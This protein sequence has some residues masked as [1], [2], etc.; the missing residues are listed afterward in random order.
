MCRRNR[1]IGSGGSTAGGNACSFVEVVDIAEQIAPHHAFKRFRTMPYPRLP[2]VLAD[3]TG[4]MERTRFA[5]AD[6]ELVLRVE[7]PVDSNLTVRLGNN[8]GG[9]Q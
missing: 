4:K 7:V 3:D 5:D 9:G 2:V 6:R 8:L 1:V